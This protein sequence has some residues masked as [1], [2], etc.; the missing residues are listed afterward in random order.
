VLK[1]G[2][3]L[4]ETE[5]FSSS[6][7][8]ACSIWVSEV[9]YYLKDIH[10]VAIYVSPCK[11]EFD[12]F[13]IVHIHNYK[14]LKIFK[15]IL[16]KRIFRKLKSLYNL[17]AA[18][19]IGTH[20]YDVVHIHNRPEYLFNMRKYNPNAKIILHMHNDHLI[21]YSN[22]EVYKICSLADIIIGCSKYITANIIKAAPEFKNKCHTVYNGVNL[23]TFNKIPIKEQNNF[24]I[25]LFVGRIVKQKGLHIL[26]QAFKEVLGVYPLA[27]LYIIGAAKATSRF[28]K[29]SY[30]NYLKT[31]SA[32]IKDNVH[33]IGRVPNQSLA[34]YYAFADVFVCPSIWEEP[35]GM[36]ITEAMA[37]ECAVVASNTGGIPEVVG[38]TGILVDPNNVSAL[39][40]AIIRIL[41][42]PQQ[43]IAY[44]SKA[45]KRAEDLFSWENIAKSFDKLLLLTA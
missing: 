36:V 28:K 7:G 39:K 42:N 11:K 17:S 31:L 25:I 1:I 15:K 22:K 3:V 24:P 27:R 14:Y 33:F 9:Y 13:D 34:A 16:H 5:F 8:G 12:S 41:N 43:K 19:H 44:G 4:S 40:S 10:Q 37:C 20:N 35:F 18:K 38:D 30:L 32:G 26:I 45:R 21:K 29:N 23:K 6:Y 2:V